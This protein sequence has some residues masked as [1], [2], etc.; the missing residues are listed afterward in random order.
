M[1]EYSIDKHP[2]VKILFWFALLAIATTPIVIKMLNFAASWTS[3][4]TISFSSSALFY[5]IY[6]LFDKWGWRISWFR[7]IF[8]V[9]DLNGNWNCHGLTLRQGEES[10]NK[11][12]DSSITIVQSWSKIIVHLKTQTSQSQSTSAS[13]VHEDGNGY[14]LRFSYSNTPKSGNDELRPH[15][16]FCEILFDKEI[17]NGD[18]EYFTNHQ[19]LTFGT[20]KLTKK[21]V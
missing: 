12:W 20:M 3:M 6:L 11:E 17:K 4:G 5:V 2:K 14:R 21:E 8:L 18:G 19:R 15:A 7:K 16:G 13:V 10:P 1:H 9:P